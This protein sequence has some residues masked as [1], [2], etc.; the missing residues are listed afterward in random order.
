MYHSHRK[1]NTGNKQTIEPANCFVEKIGGWLWIIIIAMFSSILCA[2]LISSGQKEAYSYSAAEQS[3]PQGGTFQT[4]ALTQ[5]PY[6]PGFLDSEG[7]CH[8][9]ECPIYS[10][11]W[12]K[13][14]SDTDIP[15]RRALI[16]ELALEVGASQG[17]GS[18]IIQAVYPGG[19]A[20]K[21]GLHVGDRIV[22]FNGR[23]VKNVK[24]FTSIV[25]RAKPESDVEV[26]VIR[27]GRKVKEFVMIGEGEMEGVTVPAK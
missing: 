21:A 6:C 26:E 15:V 9:P 8:V 7:K 13:A 1:S 23:K 11:D 4:I 22:R 24:Q 12:G 10:P 20:E 25:A 27:E 5:C 19:N 17:R 3:F 2:V 14:V 16:R 18:V